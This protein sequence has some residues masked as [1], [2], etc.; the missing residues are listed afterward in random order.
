MSVRM[1]LKS[2]I[3]FCFTCFCLQGELLGGRSPRPLRASL[4]SSSS[5]SSFRQ[6][7]S[8]PRATFFISP[9]V[10]KV[11]HSLSLNGER[12]YNSGSFMNH[13]PEKNALL[14]SEHITTWQDDA[15]D[16]DEVR[17]KDL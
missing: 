1:H 3:D 17:I 8:S 2:F 12:A 14:H 13:Q 16:M 5:T 9:V 11:D 4:V 15:V 6:A 7:L 10:P